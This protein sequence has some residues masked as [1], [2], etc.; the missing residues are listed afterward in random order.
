MG[1]TLA[2]ETCRCSVDPGI[3]ILKVKHPIE[4]RHLRYFVAVA[5]AESFSGA[6]RRLGLSQPAI[7]QQ[8]RQFE[9]YVGISLFRRCGKRTLLTPAGLIFLKRAGEIIRQ[10]DELISDT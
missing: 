5:E 4:I 9:A 3:M 8:M 10:F 1:A 6:A 7:S 2:L